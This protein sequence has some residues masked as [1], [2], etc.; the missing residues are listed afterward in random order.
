MSAKAALHATNAPAVQAPT[1]AHSKIGASSMHRWAECPGSVRLSEGIPN[2]TS[3]YAEEGHNAHDLAAF[4]LIEGVYDRHPLASNEEML[5]H[6]ETYVTYVEQIAKDAHATAA[7]GTYLVEHKFDLSSLHPG[8]FGTADAVIYDQSRKI[9]HVV[10]FKYGAGVPVEVEHNEQLMYYGLGALLSLNTPCERVVL[11]I[12]QPRCPHSKG[13]S[14][15]WELPALELVDFAAD[16]VDFA[17]K[18]EDP[19]AHVKAGAHCRFCPAQVICPEMKQKAQKLAKFEFSEVQPASYD[20]RELGELLGWLDV[21]DDWIK[22]V[23]N[24]AYAEVERGRAVPGW[25]L[26]AKRASRKWTD[27]AAVEA[28]LQN[29]FTPPVL[30]ELYDQPTLKSVAQVEKVLSKVDAEKIKPF[31]VSISSGNTLVPES[32]GRAEVKVLDAKSEFS[33]IEEISFD[34]FS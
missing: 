23:R 4:R 22:G 9:L 18:T 27:V 30:R 24:F 14:R 31:I 5:S 32:D 16:L 7:D 2:H 33:A 26:V 10:D 3:K 28:M 6:V 19:F 13:S 1:A 34:P 29:T 20:A 21:F 8:L 11:H 25:K 15:S 12:V 17:K